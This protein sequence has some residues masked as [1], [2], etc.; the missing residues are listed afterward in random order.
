[1]LVWQIVHYYYISLPFNNVFLFSLCHFVLKLTLIKYFLCG[2]VTN[3]PLLFY[4]LADYTVISRQS[5]S[6]HP[7]SYLGV[8]ETPMQMVRAALFNHKD[9]I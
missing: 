3:S 9:S 2:S 1:M 4:V 8:Q 7:Q 6:C 5:P